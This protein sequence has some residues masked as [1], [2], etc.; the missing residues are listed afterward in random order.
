MYLLHFVILGHETFVPDVGE[1]KAFVDGNVGGVLVGGGFDG[2]LVGVL[3]LSYVRL[4][5][6][7]FV[8]VFLLLHLLLPFLAIVPVTIVTPLVLLSLKLEH[9]IMSISISC[10][11]HT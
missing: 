2:A 8:V 9:N 1:E 3:F 10:V 7:L 4:A 11:C 6:L 5:T